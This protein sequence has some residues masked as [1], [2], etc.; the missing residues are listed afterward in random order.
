MYEFSKSFGPLGLHNMDDQ[1]A[2]HYSLLNDPDPLYRL[3][4]SVATLLAI[5]PAAWIAVRYRNCFTTT[6]AARR[7]YN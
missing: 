2:R 3:M 6:T 4:A 1:S 5:L 7:A